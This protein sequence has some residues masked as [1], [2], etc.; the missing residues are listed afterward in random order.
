M[1]EYFKSDHS[2]GSIDICYQLSFE[3]SVTLV[4]I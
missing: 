1:Q 2:G 3:F 4:E